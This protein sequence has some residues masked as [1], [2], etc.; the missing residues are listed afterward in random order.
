M[1]QNCHV[2]LHNVVVNEEAK[3]P[4]AVDFAS[5]VNKILEHSRVF[6]CWVAAGMC[7]GVY[8][9]AIKYTSNRKQFGSS[10]TSFQLV[11]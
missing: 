2:I 11:Q 1:V 8:D 7:M 5:G 6:V 10:I 3:L 9:S 4:K